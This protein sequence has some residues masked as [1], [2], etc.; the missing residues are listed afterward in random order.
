MGFIINPFRFVPPSFD[1][2]GLKAYWKYEESSGNIINQAGIIGSTDSL[3]SAADII[4]NG[5]TYDVTGIIDKAI[6]FDGVDDFGDVGS[7]VSQFDFILSEAYE[8]TIIIWFKKLTASPNTQTVFMNQR[9]AANDNGLQFKFDDRSSTK[10]FE[11]SCKQS[12][13]VFIN[14]IIS[15]PVIPQ[16]TNFHMMV[17][18]GLHSENKWQISIDN[19]TLTD[20][21]ESADPSGTESPDIPFEWCQEVA[22]QFWAGIMDEVSIWNR[23]LTNDELTT[24]FNSGAAKAL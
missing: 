2:T 14:Q 12:G 8:F 22:T 21:S 16:D 3:G 10:K 13:T 6:S 1:L 15:T 19:G 11:L 5:V 17:L 9:G 24:L 4:V 20:I 7:S 23:K 18:R